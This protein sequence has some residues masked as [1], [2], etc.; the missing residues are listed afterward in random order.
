MKGAQANCVDGSV[1][2]ASVLRQIGIDPVLVLIPG[3]MFVGFFLDR[4]HKQV[5][6]LETTMLGTAD[7]R[8]SANPLGLG[9]QLGRDPSWTTFSQA[10]ETANAE[11]SQHLSEFNS[12]NPQYQLIDLQK[13]RAAGILPIAYVP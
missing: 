3:H 1:L 12:A 13:A 9:Q 8:P 11:V 10:W 2:F 4:A 6:Y 7:L 5:F